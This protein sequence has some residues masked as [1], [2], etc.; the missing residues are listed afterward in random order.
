MAKLNQKPTLGVIVGNRG[1]FPKHLCVEGRKTVLNVLSEMGI[2]AVIA[3][4]DA[5]A[6]GSVESMNEA[7]LYADLFKQHRDEIDERK[8]QPGF[9]SE[10]K[11]R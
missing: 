10:N 4:E 1:F 6:Y 5:T 9:G 8:R 11:P 7:R 3:P 2:N